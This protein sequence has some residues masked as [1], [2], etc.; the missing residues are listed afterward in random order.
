MGGVRNG[1]AFQSHFSVLFKTD[2]SMVAAFSQ[3][4]VIYGMI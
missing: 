2:L 1:F 4:S 3:V